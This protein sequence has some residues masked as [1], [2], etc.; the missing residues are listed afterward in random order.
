MTED[1]EQ[2]TTNDVAGA[3]RAMA[4]FPWDEMLSV[5]RSMDEALREGKREREELIGALRESGAVARESPGLVASAE[6]I[7]RALEAATDQ[8]GKASATLAACAA[9]LARCESR[10]ELTVQDTDGIRQRIGFWGLI[11]SGILLASVWDEMLYLY[12]VLT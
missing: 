7:S 12:Q 10:L 11:V 4:N 2:V 1:R 3:I 8:Q 5:Q 6:A 9:S